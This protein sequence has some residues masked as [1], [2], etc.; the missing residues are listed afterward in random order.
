MVDTKTQ[1]PKKRERPIDQ[2]SKP[3]LDSIKPM[4]RKKKRK[5]LAKEKHKFLKPICENTQDLIVPMDETSSHSESDNGLPELHLGVF[6]DLGNGEV[7]VRVAAAERLVNELK[8]VQ[9]VFEK[10]GG[11]GENEGG[12]MLEAEKDDGLNGCAPSVRYAVRRLIRGVSSSREVCF[13]FLLW[14]LGNLL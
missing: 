6:K 1:K 13:W 14:F 7:S 9:R 5:A 4:E 11:D 12:L 3:N 10:V 8:E 2:E